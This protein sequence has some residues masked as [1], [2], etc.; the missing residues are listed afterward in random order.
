MTL[1]GVGGWSASETEQ[2]CERINGLAL[3]TLVDTM[4]RLEAAVADLEGSGA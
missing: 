4:D 2:L 1:T 3:A